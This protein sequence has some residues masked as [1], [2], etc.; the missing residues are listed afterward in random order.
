VGLAARMARVAQNG[1]VRSAEGELQKLYPE[2]GVWTSWALWWGRSDVRPSEPLAEP[3]LDEICRQRLAPLL[4]SA[5]AAAPTN[6]IDAESI[7]ALR[8]DAFRRAISAN[9]AIG[10][11]QQALKALTA[12]SVPYA[13]TK[14]PGIARLYPHPGQRVFSDIDVLVPPERFDEAL[15]ALADLGFEEPVDIRQVREVV[16]RRCREAINL[17]TAAGGSIDL[18]HHLPPWLWGRGIDACAV[19]DAAS[20]VRA[21]SV[22]LRCASAEHNLL[23]AALHVVS[24]KNRPGATL[25]I[26]RD[27]VELA[28]AAEVGA[29][30]EQAR[31]AGLCGWLRGV[32][33]ALPPGMRPAE[34]LAALELE[35]TTMAH[36]ARLTWLLAHRDGAS[37]TATQF[38]RLPL[39]R[40]LLY[41]AGMAVPGRVFL[42]DHGLT[43][44][45]WLRD[46]LIRGNA[47][48][49]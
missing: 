33:L 17:A 40:G 44:R 10:Q 28:H 21:G 2:L 12:A 6:L 5:L 16:G 24:D 43:Y 31:A 29:V 19:V 30:I 11:S 7:A 27:V 41:L 42:R 4:L 46:G 49:S 37:V 26:W 25:L 39:L 14:G 34:L 45:R 18:H 47:A 1:S 20:P 3:E 13:V 23:V 22:E 35:D 32:L 9:L 36:P 15:Q 8:R 48:P 38:A